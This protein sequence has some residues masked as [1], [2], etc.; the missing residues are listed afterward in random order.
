MSDKNETPKETP[1][2]P[3]TAEEVKVEETPKQEST[4]TVTMPIPEPRHKRVINAVRSSKIAHVCAG[5][6]GMLGV[7]VVIAA[8]KGDSTPETTTSVSPEPLAL[9]METVEFDTSVFEMETN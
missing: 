6:V 8:V 3:E 4:P 9:P 2:T 5:A 1:E 7:L